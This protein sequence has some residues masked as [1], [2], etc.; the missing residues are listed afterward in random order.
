MVKRQKIVEKYRRDGEKIGEAKS[1]ISRFESPHPPREISWRI[2][3]YVMIASNA[4]Y[5]IKWTNG[6]LKSHLRIKLCRN[7]ASDILL[8]P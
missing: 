3:Q 8:A 1:L 5:R 2:L 4:K 6:T 7:S